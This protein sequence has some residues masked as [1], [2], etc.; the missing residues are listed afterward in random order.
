[1][2]LLSIN[3]CHA[4]LQ[5]VVPGARQI[6]AAAA[7]ESAPP[8]AADS[9]PVASSEQEAEDKMFAMEVLQV[10]EGCL[11]SVVGLC[12]QKSACFVLSCWQ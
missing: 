4:V 5:G 3:N 8:A 7:A 12:S 6:V 2:V 11:N 1:M 10:C 9:T